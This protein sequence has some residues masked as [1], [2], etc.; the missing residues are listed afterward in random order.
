MANAMAQGTPGSSD[1]QRA[2]G[3]HEARLSPFARVT[4]L[5]LA[6]LVTLGT[7]ALWL[8]NLLGALRSEAGRY[9]FSTY[10]AAAAALRH[11]LHANI[12]D[13]ATLARTGANAHTLVNPPLP[14]TYPPLFAI[15]LSPFTLLSF[16]T[17][18][19]VW[20][21]GNAALWLAITLL[22]AND[23]RYLLADRL[24]GGASA[25]IPTGS[26]FAPARLLFD[27]APLVALALAVLIS[28]P[29]AP[30]QQ[31]LAT[32]QIN[33]VVLA[34]LALIP[35]LSRHRHERWVGVMVAIAA[36]LKFTPAI[37][38]LYL[39]L[40][41]RWT[42]LIAALVALVALTLVSVAV[43]GPSV[44]FA[45]LPQALRVGGGD[46]SLGH[47]E[48][49]FAPLL[50]ALGYPSA[51]KLVEYAVL[52]LLA[53]AIGALLWRD[54]QPALQVNPAADT[55]VAS[56]YSRAAAEMA[57][58]G[59]ALCAMILLSP[60]AWVHHYVWLLPAL[61]MGVGLASA[62]LLA[63]YELP[64]A[65]GRGRAWALV[66]AVTLAALALAWGLPH[67]WDTDPNPAITTLLG[68]P[69]HTPLLEL[70]PLAALALLVALAI[71]YRAPL[72]APV[73]TQRPGRVP[74]AGYTD[75]IDGVDAAQATRAAQA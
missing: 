45:A 57:G 24:T 37:L 52:A 29:F 64:G 70:R 35:W 47:N 14:Y 15:L 1:I 25:P 43:V 50:S 65:R 11:N 32:G 18:S 67:A 17:L 38:L 39:A 69:L 75:S 40:R 9:D 5:A 28:L 34:P 41:R 66:A 27:P 3:Q 68:L 46:A 26:R 51:L 33:F 61:A 22:L 6:A 48:A 59:I 16:H 20:L 71:C 31:T 58:Y 54:P 44:A 7:L 62:H 63:A 36:M 56:D 8:R 74:A 30:A 23:I 55:G 49:L 10:Y 2:Q 72:P 4:L 19:R 42:A 60:T 12:Y 13:A 73:A 53:L 21:L